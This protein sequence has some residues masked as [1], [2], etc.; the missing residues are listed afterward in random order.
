MAVIS[1][2]YKGVSYT[3]RAQQ[4]CVVNISFSPIS[5]GTGTLTVN[6]FSYTHTTG[7][8]IL[9]GEVLKSGKSVTLS[10]TGHNS[11]FQV[12]IAGFTV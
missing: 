10:V 5:G 4:D 7:V 6:G 1:E 2:Y 9:S 3:W 12:R 11:V 8:L